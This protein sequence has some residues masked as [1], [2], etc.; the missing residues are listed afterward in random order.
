MNL[1]WKQFLDQNYYGASEEEWEALDEDNIETMKIVTVQESIEDLKDELRIQ[2]EKPKDITCIWQEFPGEPF[3][4]W[5]RNKVYF[6]KEND[7]YNV[8]VHSANRHPPQMR[9]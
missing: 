3:E 2:K 8:L 9:K 5:T 1:T 6:S 7:S 4:V